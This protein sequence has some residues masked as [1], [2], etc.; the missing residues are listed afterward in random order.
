MTIQK[1]REKQYILKNKNKEYEIPV[2]IQHWQLRDMLKA[3]NGKLY[4][5]QG[6]KICSFSPEDEQLSIL[7]DDLLFFPTSLDVSDNLCVVGGQKGQFVY[8]NLNNNKREEGVSSE[9]INNAVKIYEDIQTIVFC[10]NDS[11]VK[12]FD[13]NTFKMSYKIK[14]EWPVNNCEFSYNRKYLVSVGDTNELKIFGNDGNLNLLETVKT[15]NDGGFKVSWNPLDVGFAV[16]TQDG[17]VCVFD[18]R[19]LKKTVIKAK[20]QSLRGAC[21]NVQYSTTE[22]VDLLLFTEHVSCF[23]LVDARNNNS[24]Q[25]INVS[26]YDKQISGAAFLEGKNKIY[27][28]TDDKIYEYELNIIQRRVFSEYQIK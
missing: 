15:T 14:H 2:P 23:T 6:N 22:S 1:T 3:K 12:F 19:N 8:L 18:I 17:Y 11:T 13:S 27:I 10:S 25:T 4:F 7:K 20:Q 16:S 26:S 5:C 24:K 21:R 28:S 9:A